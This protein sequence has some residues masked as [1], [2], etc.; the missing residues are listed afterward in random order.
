MITFARTYFGRIGEIQGDA[1]V[2]MYKLLKSHFNGKEVPTENG[3]VSMGMSETGMR[4]VL[5]DGVP[6]LRLSVEFTVDTLDKLEKLA[7]DR[8]DD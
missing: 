2:K 5:V 3:V 7:Q 1:E 4:E 6:V 8:C